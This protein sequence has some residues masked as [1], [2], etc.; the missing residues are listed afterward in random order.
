MH[1][2]SSSYSIITNFGCDR[3]CPYCIS[4][5][6]GHGIPYTSL[7]ETLNSLR[8]IAKTEEMTSLSVSG[9]GDPLF[10]ITTEDDRAYWYW[11]IT[12]FC[13]LHNIKSK[14]HTSYFKNLSQTQK[15]IISKFDLVSYHL[16]DARDAQ[17]V[18]KIQKEC[19]RVVFVVTPDFTT[20]KIDEIK[21]AVSDNGSIDQ[22]TFRQYVSNDYVPVRI[23]E[24]YLSQGDYQNYWKYVRQGDY[25]NYI[26]NNKLYFRFKDILRDENFK[27][28]V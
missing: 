2:Q 14:I 10:N 24:D 22:L 13:K 23:C 17:C 21:Q 9:G 3:N 18:E 27:N 26:I 28:I 15:D 7:S 1:A 25:N 8:L 11:L 20:Q 12:S 16:F 19:V 6:G 4:K 5:T